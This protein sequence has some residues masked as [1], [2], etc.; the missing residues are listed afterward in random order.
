MAPLAPV[1]KVPSIRKMP[2]C[3]V[4]A[5]SAARAAYLKRPCRHLLPDCRQLASCIILMSVVCQIANSL[6]NN[7][8]RSHMAESQHGHM[9]DFCVARDTP[10]VL[11]FARSAIS[12]QTWR[13][14]IAQR[15]VRRI[16]RCDTF[17]Y[18]EPGRVH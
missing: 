14:T 4:R 7:R 3:P 8:T 6:T 1:M 13:P 5:A 2:D 16:T 10:K 12:H 15:T 11:A 18:G 9:D 17:L